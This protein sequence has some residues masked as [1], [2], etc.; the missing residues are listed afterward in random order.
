MQDSS[1]AAG[2]WLARAC[3]LT[4]MCAGPSPASPAA[5]PQGPASP[6]LVTWV[7]QV[8]SDN[9]ELEGAGAAV[10]AARARA[11]GAGRPLYNPELEL[12]YERSDINK[13]TAELSQPL[14]WHDKRAARAHTADSELAAARAEYDAVRER[15]AGELLGALAEYEGSRAA[16]DLAERQVAVLERFAKVARER[17]R[18]GDLEQVEV[19]LAELAYVEGEMASATARARLA[20]AVDALQRLTGT[21]EKPEADLPQA[22]AEALPKA[23]APADLA[24][25]HP[26]VQAARAR[27][28]AAGAAVRRADRERRLDPTV[29]I[30][31]GQEDDEA[32]I[33]LRL[34][35][36]LSVRNDFRAE[37]EA[38]RS[39]SVQAAQ[40][41][42]QAER[43]ALA[44]LTAA[45][46]RYRALRRAWQVWERKGRGSLEA[47][48]KL[49][50]RLW[51]VG[52]LSTTD[53]L[54]QVKQGLD[55]E[56]A[57]LTLQRELWQAWIGW[58]RAAGQVQTWL[59]PARGGEAR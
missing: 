19:E 37:V 59:G 34:S 27:A 28:Q 18:A 51:G 16:A 48:L 41:A 47:R 39:E 44:R 22:P 2:A 21:A 55:T 56:S 31:G 17:G 52:E 9:P 20:D 54:V 30:K 57:G 35:I 45:E 42:G 25:R 26:E 29:G 12:E 5:P 14:D 3:V 40:T 13:T 33:G 11:A 23:G 58:L 43:Q 50:D 8:L 15:L 32:L 1:V 4:L 53:Y 38:A 24:G 36:P 10:E 6:R 49:L 7:A 46:A